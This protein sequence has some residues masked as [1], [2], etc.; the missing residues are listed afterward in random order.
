MTLAVANDTGSVATWQ[1]G[2]MAVW[3]YGSGCG[4]GLWLSVAVAN[5]TLVNSGS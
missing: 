4:C 3:L 5:D 2:Y 1:C